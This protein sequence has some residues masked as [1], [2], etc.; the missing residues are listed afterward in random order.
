MTK[1]EIND[2]KNRFL[3]ISESVQQGLEPEPKITDFTI[4]KELGAGSFGHVYLVTHKKTK[5][6]YAIKQ[7]IKIIT[8]IILLICIS[9]H[10]L[11]L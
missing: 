4:S 6:N 3:P 7:C 11:H 2:V 5:A 9:F 10:Y 8:N 1:I